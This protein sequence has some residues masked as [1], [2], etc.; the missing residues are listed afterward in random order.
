[1]EVGLPYLPPIALAQIEHS[2]APTAGWSSPYEIALLVISVLLF[3]AFGFWEARFAAQPIMPLRIWIAPS[4]FALVIVVLFSF[5]A[6]GTF[7]WYMVAWQQEIRHWS[8]LSL[9]AGLTPLP[10]CAA[11][12]AILAS[13]LIPR[14]AAQWIL[15]IGCITV[16]VA[17]ILI[18]TMPE[19][20]A[21]WAQVFPATI[22]QSF[23]PDFIFTAAQMIACNSVRRHEQGI[24]GSLVGTLQ[25]YATSLGLGFAGIV[26]RH[27]DQHG[28]ELFFGMGLAV[29]A[30]VIGGLFVR[31]PKDTREGWQ[32]DDGEKICKKEQNPGQTV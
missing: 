5:M 21:Y 14:L 9:A 19:Q 6:Y 17:Q 28:L 16:L 15:A 22:V 26:E 10:I 13:W 8:V 3:L 12:A 23:C 32:G 7:I 1:M 31:M 27:T 4:F 2:Q 11:A 18:A 29:T 25:L 24:A 20:Q 30:L